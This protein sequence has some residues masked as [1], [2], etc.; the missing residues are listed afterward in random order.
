MFN[1]LKDGTRVLLVGDSDQL[2]SVGP[3]NVFR[4]IIESNV[5][6]VVELKTIFR[7]AQASS[8]VKD[9]HLINRSLAPANMKYINV[10]KNNCIT[11]VNSDGGN[12]AAP[13]SKT[14]KHDGDVLYLS[15]ND[16]ESAVNIIQGPLLEYIKGLGY[17]IQT[18]VQFLAPMIRGHCGTT[19][20]CNQVQKVIHNIKEDDKKTNKK[21]SINS[22]SIAN[23]ALLVGDR[24]MQD[25]ND[26]ALG[27]WNGEIGTIVEKNKVTKGKDKGKF[28]YK[29]EFPDNKKK[30]RIITYTGAAVKRLKLAYACTIHKSQGSE[31]PVVII[32][33]FNE[34][35]HMLSK[36][37]LYTALTRA[38]S[39]AIIIGSK[40]MLNAT[41]KKVDVSKRQTGLK[42]QIEALV[43]SYNSGSAK[44]KTMTG[45]HRTKAI[46]RDRWELFGLETC[47]LLD[48]N[49]AGLHEQTLDTDGNPSLNVLDESPGQ[50]DHGR[51]ISNSSSSSNS[52]DANTIGNTSNHNVTDT[53]YQKSTNHT[54][55]NKI[56]DNLWQSLSLE[57][58]LINK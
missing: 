31:F 1:A 23:D 39:L 14:G 48:D 41:V 3:G 42:E 33:L 18:D 54:Q 24:V 43:E 47:V 17:N 22:S 27:V 25:A 34:H 40:R 2:P 46:T 19:N 15:E 51:S 16:S 32:P 9:A 6:P 4:N 38:E 5:V 58:E 35:Y 10:N 28:H 50:Y 37:L 56:D 13:T 8:I 55:T 45:D 21:K 53:T 7:Q 52:K 26:Y 11:M 12:F 36:N 57:D 29:V 30:T 44:I 49:N 20:I